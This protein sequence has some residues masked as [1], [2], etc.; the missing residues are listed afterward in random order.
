MNLSI[1]KSQGAEI[2]PKTPRHTMYRIQRHYAPLT[3]RT[4]FEV[5]RLLT[6]P[7]LTYRTTHLLVEDSVPPTFASCPIAVS[8]PTTRRSPVLHAQRKMV[9][10]EPSR[11][12]SSDPQCQGSPRVVQGVS[13]RRSL[14]SSSSN[15][16]LGEEA[17]QSLIPKPSGELGH[18]SR[19]GYSLL[20]VL[21]RVQKWDRDKY[22]QVKV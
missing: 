22:S 20:E 12:L 11:R 4:S 21:R 13:T 19:D 7:L 2:M 14:R 17:P 1:Q 16:H 6:P 8:I 18:P 5:E 10:I 3:Y 9:T 15:H